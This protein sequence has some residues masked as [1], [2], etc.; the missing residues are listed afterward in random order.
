MKSMFVFCTDAGKCIPLNVSPL[1]SLQCSTDP[2]HQDQRCTL[3]CKENARFI[4]LPGN[5][6]IVTCGPATH[7]EWKLSGGNVT[8]IPTCSG[9]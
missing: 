7:F 8:E 6:V 2:A 4:S 3:R 5:E 9:V 1:A